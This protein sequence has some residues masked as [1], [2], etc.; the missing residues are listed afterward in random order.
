MTPESF[1]QEYLKFPDICIDSRAAKPGSVFIALNGENFNG[2]AY[3]AKALE[4]GCV[5]AL[6]DESEWIR[7]DRYVLVDDGLTFLQDL[8]RY[9]RQ[10]L[11]IPVLA[12]TG[13]NGKTT[14]K[15][16]I[17]SVLSAKHQ[18]IYTSGNLNNHIGVPLT[19]LRARNH[20]E[21]LVI[22]M[23]AN[24]GGEIELLC[25]IAQPTMGLITNIGQA[26]L[27]GFGSF[28]GVIKAKNEL[29]DYLKANKAAI[30][31]NQSDKILSRL[32]GD[33]P[34]HPYG[35]DS[36][37][38]SIIEVLDGLYHCFNFDP[39]G[40]GDTIRIETRL[41]GAYNLSN[42]L[43]AIEIGRYF[44]IS[45]QVAAKRILEYEPGMN[46]SQLKKTNS[47]TLILDAYNAN[48][49]SMREAILN[50]SAIRQENKLAILGD[51]LELGEFSH[52]AHKDILDLIKE[53]GLECILVGPEFLKIKAAKS[54]LCFPDS[55]KAAAYLKARP[56]TNK[57]ILLKGSRGIRL[58]EISEVL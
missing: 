34:A 43:A 31:F 47:N 33:Y 22:E 26:H 24:H 51:M 8:A 7:D 20:H 18:I 54:F 21:V 53:V 19:I 50:F 23:G 36:Q 57:L 35:Q 9:H 3:A 14:T 44:G 27:E 30:F 41:V 5:K 48:P 52:D 11:N 25:A 56:F 15:E 39:G 1:Y 12:L 2:N 29:F 45:L 42:V 55:L 58:E 13:T 46:R 10:Q 49:S 38:S 32:I 37:Q 40:E 16:L 6:V 28:E 4:S 17:A